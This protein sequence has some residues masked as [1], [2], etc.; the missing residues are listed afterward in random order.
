M[1]G[2]AQIFLHLIKFA[3]MDDRNGIFLRIDRLGFHGRIQLGKRHGNRVGAQCF[4]RIDIHRI[5]HDTQFESGQIRHLRHRMLAVR[6]LAEAVFPVAQSHH[7]LA[8]RQ[9]EQA[10]PQFAVKHGVSL[11]LVLEQQRQI[12]KQV[13]LDDRRDRRRSNDRHLLNT[14]A[15]GG[16]HLRFRAQLGGGINLDLDF[17]A[18]QAVHDFSKFNGRLSE[19]MFGRNSVSQADIALLG[20]LR[21]RLR[22]ITGQCGSGQYDQK[23]VGMHHEDL[24]IKEEQKPRRRDLP[25]QPETTTSKPQYVPPQ[26]GSKVRR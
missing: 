3:R 12:E 19:R 13:F 15:H 20:I 23:F 17:S 11:F 10:L 1:V 21:H 9:I 14:A 18:A 24:P 26:R 8:R 22:S 5:L 7:A 2:Q 4:K 16:N 25:C 6:Y